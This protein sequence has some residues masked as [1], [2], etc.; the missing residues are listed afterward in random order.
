MICPAQFQT[1]A[2]HCVPRLHAAEQLLLKPT[3]G[4]SPLPAAVA[5]EVHS[6]EKPPFDRTPSLSPLLASVT[7]TVRR[8]LV[9]QE[10]FMPQD[11]LETPE[12]LTPE[13]HED[14]VDLEAYSDREAR[15]DPVKKLDSR[16]RK[17][18]RLNGV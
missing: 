11:N 13:V 5:P 3:P 4:S 2:R 16:R 12:P 6:T 8:T 9:L 18:K 15:P 14:A 10:A 1:P 7:P 17:H